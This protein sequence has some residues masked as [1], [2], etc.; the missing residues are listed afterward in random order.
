MIKLLLYHA[1]IEQCINQ[2]GDALHS[3]FKINRKSILGK[4]LTPGDVSRLVSVELKGLGWSTGELIIC[5][6]ADELNAEFVEA[7]LTQYAI[8]EYL[9]DGTKCMT[10]IETEDVVVFI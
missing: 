5:D 6:L 1:V 10:G 8:L 9:D 2:L 7:Q 3:N 4:D